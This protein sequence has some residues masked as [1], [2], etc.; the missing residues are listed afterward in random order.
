MTLFA[1]KRI[2][3]FEYFHAVLRS[4]PMKDFPLFSFKGVSFYLAH[5]IMTM[6]SVACAVLLNNYM[7]PQ[8]CTHS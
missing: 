5:Q 4:P 3:N 6:T 1:L 2:F 8:L 7:L